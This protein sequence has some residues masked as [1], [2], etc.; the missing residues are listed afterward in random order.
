MLWALL[1]NDAAHLIGR[2]LHDGAQ[3]TEGFVGD[4]YWRW[5]PAVE[6]EEEGGGYGD[7]DGDDGD[8]E[9]EEAEE[10]EPEHALDFGRPRLRVPVLRKRPG[11]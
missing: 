6:E 5:R 3:D 10:E 1:I 9:E 4:W 7:G 11:L 8:G 2:A